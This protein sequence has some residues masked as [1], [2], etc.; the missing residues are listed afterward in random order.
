MSTFDSH[1]TR[2]EYKETQ[3]RK[4]KVKETQRAICCR[5]T[6]SAYTTIYIIK[7]MYESENTVGQYGLASNACMGGDLP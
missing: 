7:R 4:Y 1:W 2:N 5:F 3:Q 6:Y